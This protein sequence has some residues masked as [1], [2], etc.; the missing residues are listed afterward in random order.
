MKCGKIT[1]VKN[2]ET[3]VTLQIIAVTLMIVDIPEEN[4]EKPN[5]NPIPGLAQIVGLYTTM[6]EILVT[7]RATRK[8]F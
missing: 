1:D 2:G 5:K 3:S 8:L 7:I 4:K 6:G